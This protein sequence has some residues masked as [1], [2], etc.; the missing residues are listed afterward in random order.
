MSKL[1]IIDRPRD[2]DFILKGNDLNPLASA[3]YPVQRWAWF[4]KTHPLYDQSKLVAPERYSV[5]PSTF[6]LD[7]GS[8]E[9]KP[10]TDENKL[11]DKEF[12]DIFERKHVDKLLFK[13]HGE[14]DYSVQ[15]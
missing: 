5:E 7:Q 10:S 15:G 8:K 2:E 12:N 4:Y 9:P 13:K 11:I 14:N 6:T 1:N 3:V